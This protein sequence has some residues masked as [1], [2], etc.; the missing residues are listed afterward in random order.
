M[1]G[2]FGG[3]GI[4]VGSDNGI[5]SAERR[6]RG[7]VGEDG[8]GV[9]QGERAEGGDELGSDGWAVVESGFEDERV[10]LKEVEEGGGPSEE[11]GEVAG[12]P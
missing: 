4:G 5:P 6:R 12:R 3:I 8:A 10:E 1:D 11:G 2:F 7:E 9:G